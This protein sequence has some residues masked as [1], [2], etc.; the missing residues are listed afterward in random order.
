MIVCPQSTHRRT[1][2]LLLFVLLIAA[3]PGRTTDR[4]DAA[5]PRIDFNRQVRAILSD[6][7]FHC[8]GPDEKNREAGL[9]LDER[10]AVLED[11]GSG[12]V[13]VP[14]DPN[15]SVLIHR[16]IEICRQAFLSFC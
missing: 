12:A 7:C 4:G 1:C 5:E 10:S 8:H 6:R 2:L 14:G 15:A 3:G 11:L 9:R 16:V 13:I